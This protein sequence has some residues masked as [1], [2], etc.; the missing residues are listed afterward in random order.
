MP[1]AGC[2]NLAERVDGA[3]NYTCPTFTDKPAFITE[4]A[5]LVVEAVL[6]EPFIAKPC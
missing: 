1:R 4:G 3:L 5:N 6:N 2:P